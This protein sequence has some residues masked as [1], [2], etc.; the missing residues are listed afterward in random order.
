M[1][2][3]CAQNAVDADHFQFKKDVRD[4]S[5]LEVFTT[6]LESERQVLHSELERTSRLEKELRKNNKDEK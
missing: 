2:H 1:T 6:M 3:V 5:E 4:K